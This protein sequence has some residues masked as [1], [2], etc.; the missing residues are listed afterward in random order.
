MDTFLEFATTRIIP[1]LDAGL[2]TSILLIIPSSLL[3]MA[4]GVTVGTARVY[5][6][7]PVVRVLDWYVSLFRGTPLVVQLYFWYFALPYVAIGDFRLVLSP[8]WAAIVGFALC[9]G[10]YQSEYIRGGLLSIKR[11][12]L[13]AAQALGMTP[14]TT[15]TSVVLPQAF[16][17]ALPGCGNEIIYL[18]KYSSLASIITVS[19]L[20]GMG[21]SLAKATFRNTEVF[22]VVGLY[23]LA[24]VTVATFVLRAVEKRLELP[25][26]ETKKD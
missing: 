22:I 26:F 10:A 1:A 9:S 4:I 8:M 14:L 17:R 18:I 23:Y 15:I 3:G 24:L 6:P 19:D 25:G 20:T 2:W 5:A 13:R 11:G 12:Q 7:R 21:R 16:R